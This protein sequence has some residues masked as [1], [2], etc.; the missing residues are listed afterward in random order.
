MTLAEGGPGTW[1]YRVCA[2]ASLAF[3]LRPRIARCAGWA[4]GAHPDCGLCVAGLVHP[5]GGRYGQMVVKTHQGII[6]A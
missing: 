1:G 4:W 3:F 2:A 6:H 5:P